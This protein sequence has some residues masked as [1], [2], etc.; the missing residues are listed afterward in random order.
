MAVLGF[1]KREVS[2]I[3]EKWLSPGFDTVGPTL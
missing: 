2:M 3:V 1:R